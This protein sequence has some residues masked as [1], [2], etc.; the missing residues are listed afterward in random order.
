MAAAG[1]YAADPHARSFMM[2]QT[3]GHAQR[4]WRRWDRRDALVFAVSGLVFF[5][6]VEAL[7]SGLVGGWRVATLVISW[8]IATVTVVALV[9]W[10]ATRSARRKR[11]T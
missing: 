4:V 6:G 10:A 2:G 1:R 8:G 11:T 3:E 5:S 9:A 7:A